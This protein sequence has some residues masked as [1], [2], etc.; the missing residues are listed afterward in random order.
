M[1]HET[2]VLYTHLMQLTAQENYKESINLFL[3]LH[4]V[5]QPCYAL[6]LHKYRNNYILN[7]K[8]GTQS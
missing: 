6:T 5:L 8:L 3:R 2:S 4:I 1:V 7:I